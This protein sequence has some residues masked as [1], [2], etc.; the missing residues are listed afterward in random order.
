MDQSVA[1][2]SLT[3]Y[4]IE[5]YSDLSS[6][7]SFTRGAGGYSGTK[8]LVVIDEGRKVTI[9]VPP[10]ERDVLSLLFDPQALTKDN[11]YEV[12][13]GD[14]SVTFAPCVHSPG[15]PSQFPGAFVVAGARCATVNVYQGTPRQMS[16]V[17]ISFGAGLCD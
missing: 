4:A 7:S 6:A 12:A 14:A 9:E 16:Q 8:V 5:Q 3:F 17:V 11:L 10:E 2:G 1:V 15:R 13:N